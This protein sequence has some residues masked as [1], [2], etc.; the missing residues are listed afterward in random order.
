MTSSM[1][2][3]MYFGVAAEEVGGQGG[4]AGGPARP[5][6]GEVGQDRE[7]QAPVPP[8]PAEAGERGLAGGQ[9]VALDLHV[10]DVLGEQPD[11]RRPDE[12]QADLGGDVGE[13]DEL[14]RGQP[15]AGGDDAGPDQLAVRARGAAAC[16]APRVA[17]RFLVGNASAA[18]RSAL[19][20]G[21]VSD[22]HVLQSGIRSQGLVAL[23]TESSGP[24]GPAHRGRR[25]L[26]LADPNRS[27]ALPTTAAP[28]GRP[29]RGP[30]R[31]TP[32]WPARAASR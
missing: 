2:M 26:T 28:A 3:A 29:P 21:V 27:A 5:E 23:P 31:R 10:E 18:E 24:G 4:G 8:V 22:G 25:S 17:G 7:E 13:E 9:R 15:D 12:H 1:P 14:T 6:V 16:R 32:R 19:S 30:C 11:Q 20:V